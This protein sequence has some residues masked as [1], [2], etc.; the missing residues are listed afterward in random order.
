MALIDFD[1]VETWVPRL[2]TALGGLVSPDAISALSGSDPEYIEDARDLLLELA[3]RD[4]VIDATLDW[5]RSETIIAYHGTRLDRTE[6]ESVKRLGLLPLDPTSRRLRLERALSKH[7][8]WTEVTDRLDAEIHAHGPRQKAGGRT[9]QVHLTLSRA[10]LT[11]SFNHYLTH[12]AEFD[13][14]VADALLGAEGLELLALDGSPR[15]VHVAVPGE[16]ALAAAHPFFPIESL[17]ANGD[18]PNIASQFL[19][20]WSYRLSHPEFQP[21]ALQVDCGLF[22][23]SVLPASWVIKIELLDEM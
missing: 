11:E 4:E 17:R 19:K 8:R 13:Q 21:R 2:T 23:R 18:V 5:I 10:G 20:A 1:E 12:G 9:G 16:I 7:R 14:R 22:F 6:T 3:G 15:L